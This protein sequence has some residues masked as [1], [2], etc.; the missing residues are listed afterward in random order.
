MK[1]KRQGKNDFFF[2]KKKVRNGEPYEKNKD[3]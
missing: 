1:K 3:Q 2:I